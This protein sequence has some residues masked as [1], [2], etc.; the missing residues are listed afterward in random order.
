MESKED[1]AFVEKQSKV[2]NQPEEILEATHASVVEANHNVLTKI[3]TLPLLNL[4]WLGEGVKLTTVLLNNCFLLIVCL[5]LS[6]M[7]GGEFYH[8][9]S[10]LLEFTNS[11]KFC[12]VIIPR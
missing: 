10:P 3:D 9:H 11:S 4:F 12:L 7:G 6:P 2:T 8:L 5:S 1:P